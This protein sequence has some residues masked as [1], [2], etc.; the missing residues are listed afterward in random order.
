MAD[1]TPPPWAGL[2]AGKAWTDEKAGAAFENPLAIAEGAPDAPYEYAVWRPF[3]SLAWGDGNTGLLYDHA[4]DGAVALVTTPAFELG[5]DYMLSMAELIG[6]GPMLALNNGE[7]RAS[8]NVGSDVNAAQT[9]QGW[10]TFQNPMLGR[11]Y[12][13]ITGFVHQDDLGSNNA[14]TN[15]AAIPSG[16]PERVFRMRNSSAPPVSQARIGPM[17]GNFGGGKV[18]LYKRRT[19]CGVLA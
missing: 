8:T 13:T 3:N 1:W 19:N 6:T 14:W 11:R 9:R 5:W 16:Q 18:W 15:G 17:S 2:T 12:A 4:V 10:L 7:W